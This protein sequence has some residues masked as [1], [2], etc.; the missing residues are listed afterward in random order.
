MAAHPVL[1]ARPTLAD[2]QAYMAATN[3][4]RDHNSSTQACLLLLCEEVGEFAKAIRK[5]AGIK[6]DTAKA[7]DAHVDE[8]AADIL[9]MLCS[10]CNSLNIDLEQALRN[11]EEKNTRRVWQ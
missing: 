1:K 11:K 7:D 10:L 4:Y 8:E 3:V 5:S 6:I 2:I 9:W